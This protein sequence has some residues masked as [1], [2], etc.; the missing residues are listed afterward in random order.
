MRMEIIMQ[1]ASKMEE[2]EANIKESHNEIFRLM[3][4]LNDE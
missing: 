4:Q 3:E 2:M 1:I